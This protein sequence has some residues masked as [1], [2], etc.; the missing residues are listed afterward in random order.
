MPK[1]LITIIA[2]FILFTGTSLFAED[3][4]AEAL[5]K[6]VEKQFD[7]LSSLSYTV[8]KT[9]VYN[10][11]SQEE[12]WSFFYRKPNHI[13]IESSLPH[14]RI[15]VINDKHMLEYIP[16]IQKALRT[17]FKKLSEI[18]KNN[19]IANIMAR[20]AISGLRMGNYSEL[21]EKS[22]SVNT[23]G[24]THTIKGENPQF[25]IKIDGKKKAVLQTVLYK[26]DN[27]M[28][29]RTK[30]SDFI[31]TKSNTWFPRRIATT[32][33]YQDGFILTNY[34]LSDIET[35]KKLPDGLFDIILPKSTEVIE[36]AK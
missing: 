15:L 22:T 3:N 21:V 12:K 6:S 17:D 1:L 19:Q 7:D 18:E 27:S 30:S 9:T 26:E 28:K 24:T 20:V 11:N 5:F 2:L 29:I 25:E 4:S 10:T 32:H 23:S 35:N 31:K 14:E 33:P 8:K 34:L 16:K 36:S 13:R